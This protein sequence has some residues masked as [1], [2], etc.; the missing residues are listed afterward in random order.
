MSSDTPGQTL[1]SM[2]AGWKSAVSAGPDGTGFDFT[3]SNRTA[4]C[5]RRV[6][7]FLDSP[8]ADSFRQLWSE[9]AL[10]NYWM[11]NA[12][13]ILNGDEDTIE[14][15]ASLV[16][17]VRE[18][19]AYDPDWESIV[20]GP[21][22]WELYGRLH[23]D[24]EPIPTHHARE[25]LGRFRYEQHETRTEQCAEIERFR[26]EYERRAGHVTAGT[27]YEVP[28]H[29]ELDALFTLV[30]TVDRVDVNAEL[31]GPHERLYRPLI[32]FGRKPDPSE[33]LVWEGVDEVIENHLEARESGAYDDSTTEHW[34]GTYIEGWKWD[35]LEYF[36]EV[37]MEEFDLSN[38]DPDDIEP[39]FETIANP[40]ER[41]HVVGDVVR[42]MMGHR[43]HVFA[44]NDIVD[45]S[46]EHPEE[47][48]AAF[49]TLFD[50]DLFVEDRLNAFHEFAITP[51]DEND[52]SPGSILRA[53]T[54]LLMYAYP[55]RYVN[56]QYQRFSDFFEA[57]SNSGS[58]DMGFNASQYKEVLYA[59][60]DLLEQI[61]E[62]L[63]EAT[64]IDVQ[65]IIYVD[66]DA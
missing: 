37:V 36:Q 25:A 39:F 56:F 44:W 50:E 9:D 60:R 10:V 3:E 15:L 52:R 23:A 55:D 27:E 53:S 18:A 22:L 28:I 30:A 51:I 14:E 4:V 1:Q 59:C 8:S 61:E 24:R 41:V 33:Q 32:G 2:L 5:H 58:L 26:E 7:S 57:Y 65:T 12:G 31:H 42:K 6:E 66:A 11:P 63:P 46:I 49:S 40:D 20:D 54:A 35:Y 43:Q 48:A 13:A 62:R 19:E 17:D 34:G 21:G 29:V 64:M 38:L 45:H 47:A 16:D